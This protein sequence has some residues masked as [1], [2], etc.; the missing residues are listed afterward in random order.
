MD[1]AQQVVVCGIF[2]VVQAS[3]PTVGE[4]KRGQLSDGE[5]DD[6]KAGSRSSRCRVR[7][8]ND[9]RSSV[10]VKLSSPEVHVGK[11]SPKGRTASSLIL[12]YSRW[13]R[14]GAPKGPSSVR[15]AN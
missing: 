7:N 10:G 5:T 4:A 11:N 3:P 12:L 15:S 13:M 1:G 6:E 14:N 2:T 8:G 9:V